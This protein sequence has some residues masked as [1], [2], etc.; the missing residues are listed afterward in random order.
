MRPES[1]NLSVGP[2][3]RVRGGHCSGPARVRT[4]PGTAFPVAGRRRVLLALS[5]A[6]LCLSPMPAALARGQAGPG[7]RR[8]LSRAQQALVIECLTALAR[9]EV[10]YVRAGMPDALPRALD[11]LTQARGRVDQLMSRIRHELGRH[12]ERE[13]QKRVDAQWK[14]VADATRAQP[15]REIAQLMMP[16]AA[17]ISATLT[18]L[19]PEVPEQIMI[20]REGRSRRVLLLQQLLLSGVARCWD[21]RL[22]TRE[23]LMRQRDTLDRWLTARA[24]QGADGIRLQAQWN[25]FISALPSP[26]G[27]CLPDAASTMVAVCERLVAL[28]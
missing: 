12:I 1:A 5:A 13:D 11:G 7:A 16:M 3:G 14:T 22:V 9:L 21:R 26:G 10:A 4:M 18:A 20:G 23:A 17:E 27:D 19:L 6:G 28:V 24:G 15:S 2:A 25:L 8:P